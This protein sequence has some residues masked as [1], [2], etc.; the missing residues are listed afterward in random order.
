MTESKS[1]V[2]RKRSQRQISF[3][4]STSDCRTNTIHHGILISIVYVRSRTFQRTAVIP[5]IILESRCRLTV[6]LF[7][8]K[9]N[10]NDVWIF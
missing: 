8:F 5:S 6:A 2:Q 4:K 10:N 1:L 7:C 3:L 9:K